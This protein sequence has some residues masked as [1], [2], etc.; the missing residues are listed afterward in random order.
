MMF[1]LDSIV[2]YAPLVD[3]ACIED[4]IDCKNEFKDALL[5]LTP[6]VESKFLKLWSKP[7]TGLL[8]SVELPPLDCDV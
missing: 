7:T 8:V 3:E 5:P 4:D 1:L 6:R 2:G